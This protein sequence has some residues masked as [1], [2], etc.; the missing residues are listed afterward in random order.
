[1]TRAD[2]QTAQAETCR[3]LASI[4]MESICSCGTSIVASGN[5]FAISGTRW[6]AF[7]SFI[8]PRSIKFLVVHRVSSVTNARDKGRIQL[9]AECVSDRRVGKHAGIKYDGKCCH[10]PRLPLVKSGF[11]AHFCKLAK[12]LPALHVEFVLVLHR[13]IREADNA[14]VQ[15]FYQVWAEHI[16]KVGRCL[17]GE[18]SSHRYN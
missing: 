12:L 3:S 13:K 6:A 11:L 16:Q 5:A 1:M 4:R 17:R 2:A 15:Q 9:H 10:C 14:F 8:L 7:S 18:Q